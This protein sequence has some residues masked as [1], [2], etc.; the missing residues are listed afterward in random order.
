MFNQFISL[1]FPGIVIAL[2]DDLFGNLFCIMKFFLKSYIYAGICSY[3][4]N[5]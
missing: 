1:I 3:I 2:M 5:K 4:W